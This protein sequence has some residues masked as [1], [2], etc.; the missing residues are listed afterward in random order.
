MDPRPPEPD[1]KPPGPH[2]AA[3]P[4][5]RVT[6]PELPRDGSVVLF[7]PLQPDEIGRLGQYRVLSELGRG[8]MG[9]VYKA[10]DPSLDRLVAIKVLLPQLSADPH[11][12]A[13]FVREARAQARVEHEHIVAIHA[14]EDLNGIVYL[15]MPLLKGQTLAAALRQNS[16]PPLSELVRI[17]REIAEALAAAHAVG[18]VHR[19]IK[20]GNVWLEGNR[21]R[22]RVL[23]FGL[24]RAAGPIE[25]GLARALAPGAD[26]G[27]TD[28]MTLGGAIVGTP[29][30]MS[31]EQARGLPTD[32][33]SDLFSLG[34]VLYQMATGAAPFSG[35][36]TIEVMAAVVEHDPPP[37]RALAPAL[38]WALSDLIRRLLEKD[39]DL[40]PLDAESVAGEL[41]AIE[42]GP[43]PLVAVPAAVPVA[44]PDES[45]PWVSLDTPSPDAVT[46]VQQPREEK[47]VRSVRRAWQVP[48]IAT[49]AGL[50]VVAMSVAAWLKLS[51]PAP[52]A[53]PP[54]ERA[55]ATPVPPPVI[56]DK[57][58][59]PERRV[60]EPLRKYSE[61]VIR[62]DGGREVVVKPGA[63]LPDGPFVVTSIELVSDDCP[64]D[65]VERA[66]IPAFEH[67][68][69][70]RI[71]AAWGDRKPQPT[72]GQLNRMAELPAGQTLAE[73]K[74]APGPELTPEVL[75]ALKKFPN[76]RSVSLTAP[77]GDQLLKQL[78]ELK[79]DDFLGLTDLGPPG[80][81]DAGLEAI[82]QLPL[83]RVTLARSPA[84]PGFLRLIP[85][86]SKYTEINFW[87]SPIADVDLREL[88]K[89][90]NVVHLDLTATKVTDAGL[91]HLEGLKGLRFLGLAQTGVTRVGAEKLATALP[92]CRITL[93]N[94]QE[95]KPTRATN[96]G[97]PPV[98]GLMFD[99]KSTAVTIPKLCFDGKLPITL[100]AWITPAT[101]DETARY[102]LVLGEP[103]GGLGIGG[104][105][106]TFGTGLYCGDGVWMVMY[107]EV[108]LKPDE[109]VHIA[110]VLTNKRFVVYVNGK[111]AGTKQVDLGAIPATKPP[112]LIGKH[113]PQALPGYFHGT[114]H[115]VRVSRGERYDKDFTPDA[116]WVVD[117]DTVALYRFDA[118]KGTVLTD[119][120]KNAYHGTIEN[121]EWVARKKP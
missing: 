114:I 113:T 12:K 84:A 79:L 102:I 119:Y 63:P 30:Y 19:D 89:C 11:A 42:R 100:E 37:A 46:V 52:P 39:P 94:G 36:S 92:A 105:G 70:L 38:P 117:D 31:P 40:R 7:P 61:L 50:L 17:G 27:V 72:I 82:I 51:R 1:A 86:G 68:R 111:R 21:R 60:L 35:P 103:G 10:H 6:I 47:P 120:S 54:P 90:P 81:T 116:E 121:G 59:S 41:A 20:P 15:V 80:T 85:A 83:Q 78:A 97:A 9:R 18:L 98:G 69:G 4:S 49:V 107:S 66:L 3:V 58:V 45:D 53:D 91:V 67:L 77:A 24:A 73:L 2:A 110:A 57:P 75:A 62:T 8:G 26:P 13:R 43:L 96:P 71:V 108:L 99:G 23:D 48:V 76:L 74:L 106:R 55:G 29:A 22:V 95:I 14:V 115:A 104:S 65:F 5:N 64:P 28:P 32:P 33:R 88:A 101:V 87:L 56:R 109:Q 118:G 25:K 93:G 44:V 112:A 34:A 16:R